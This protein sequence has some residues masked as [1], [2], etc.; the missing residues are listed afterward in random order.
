MYPS[1]LG[2]PLV[3]ACKLIFIELESVDGGGN[4][5]AFKVYV[6]LDT[7]LLAPPSI[8]IALTVKL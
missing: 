7:V 6:A 3:G 1:H 8:D 4:W 5:V 2:M